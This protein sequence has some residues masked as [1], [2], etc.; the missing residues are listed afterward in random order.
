MSDDDE[1]LSVD[2]DEAVLEDDELNENGRPP[3]VAFLEPPPSTHDYTS[4]IEAELR[5]MRNTPD[6]FNLENIEFSLLLPA[7]CIA[8]LVITFFTQL[9]GS[10][11]EVFKV[12]F[13]VLEETDILALDWHKV[14][15][16]LASAPFTAASPNAIWMVNVFYRSELWKVT[17]AD[18][19]SLPL[20]T[21][22]VVRNGARAKLSFHSSCS[23]PC[24][25]E[26]EPPYPTPRGTGT[27]NRPLATCPCTS[28]M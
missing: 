20:F 15:I 6:V 25:L 10:R 28:G 5:K 2:I 8:P 4:L 3:A 24:V 9:V 17:Q 14:D 7:T 16:A 11:T 12:E 19:T 1:S 26:L 13:C 18:T 23:S 21:S 27:S 22:A